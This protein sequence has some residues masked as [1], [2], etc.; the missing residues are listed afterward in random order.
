[1]DAH[2]GG[3]HGPGQGYHHFA[4]LGEVLIVAIGRVDEGSSVEV[5]VMVAEEIGNLH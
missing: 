4:T 3:T 2:F 5:A 1:L